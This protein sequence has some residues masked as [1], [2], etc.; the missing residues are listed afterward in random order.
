MLLVIGRLTSCTAGCWNSGMSGLVLGMSMWIWREDVLSRS[1]EL[2]WGCDAG[3]KQSRWLYLSVRVL[4]VFIGPGVVVLLNEA[5]V[6][7]TLPLEHQLST[8]LVR[9]QV[10]LRDG[11]NETLWPWVEDKTLLSSPENKIFAHE[12]KLGEREE[13][14]RMMRKKIRDSFKK[15]VLAGHEQHQLFSLDHEWM[16]EWVLSFNHYTRS[17][18]ASNRKLRE[19]E[20]KK[21]TQ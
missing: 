9:R 19:K 16:N 5:K 2:R 12:W 18:T 21:K 13:V 3:A 6:L 10:A 14:D 11:R 20:K 4:V 7:L 8:L 1:K 15:K 17:K